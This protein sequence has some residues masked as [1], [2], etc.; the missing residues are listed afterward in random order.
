MSVLIWSPEAE[1]D[2]RAIWRYL[3]SEADASVASRHLRKIVAACEALTGSPLRGRPRDELRP[4]LRSIRI[5]PHIA[6]YRVTR[7]IEIVRVV[8][9][10][11]D[12]GPVLRLTR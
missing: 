3:T 12:L 9:E 5:A 4:G 10:R 11:R 1:G 7:D 6:F 2:L 8:H